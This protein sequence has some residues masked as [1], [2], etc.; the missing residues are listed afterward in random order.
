VLRE[1]L[2][3]FDPGSEVK[4]GKKVEWVILKGEHATPSFRRH[5]GNGGE[6]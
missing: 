4:S 2:S 5:V 3:V 1:K 6:G